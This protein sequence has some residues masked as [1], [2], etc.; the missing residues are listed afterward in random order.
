MTRWFSVPLRDGLERGVPAGLSTNI[1]LL[2]FSSLRWSDVKL[3][4]DGF[5][6]E[7]ERFSDLAW[8]GEEAAVIAA[9]PFGDEV[10]SYWL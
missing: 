2:S 4:V 9:G 8:A 3:S 6:H 5:V 7:R 10:D 1:A